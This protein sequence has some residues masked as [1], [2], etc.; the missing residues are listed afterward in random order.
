[1]SKRW[2]RRLVIVWLILIWLSTC[3]GADFAEQQRTLQTEMN[4]RQQRIECL[5]GGQCPTRTPTPTPPP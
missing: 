3:R 2:F 5:L 1:M 4:E